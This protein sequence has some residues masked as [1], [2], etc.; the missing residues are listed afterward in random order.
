MESSR[1]LAFCAALTVWALA[2]A[3]CAARSAAR[4]VGSY[5]E[6]GADLSAYKSYNWGPDEQTGTGDPRLDRNQIFQDRVQ[7]AVEKELSARRFDKATS[8]SPDLLVHYHAS[9]EQRI[10]LSGTD[11]MTP[12]PDCRPFVY[13]AGTLVIDLVEARSK[14][15][16]WRGWSEGN[17]EGVIDNQRW[18]EERI[19]DAVTEIFKR[20][21]S[22]TR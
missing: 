21:P 20:L 9:V 13:D 10:D 5:V 6:R 3:G 2:F 14:R 17:V 4:S 11:L 16:I 8:E 7:A 12:C 18:M 19:D 1:R 22:R 15:L